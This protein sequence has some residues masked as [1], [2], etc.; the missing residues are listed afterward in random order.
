MNLN[1]T[2]EEF[3]TL[4]SN[5]LLS[6]EEILNKLKITEYVYKKIIKEFHLTRPKTSKINRFKA[7]NNIEVIIDVD[8]IN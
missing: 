3:S 6:K 1:F 4:Y 2:I 7:F 5:K 8:I